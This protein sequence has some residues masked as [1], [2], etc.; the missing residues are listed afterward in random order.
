MTAL[1]CYGVVAAALCIGLPI[2][3]WILDPILDRLGL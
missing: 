2:I 3:E 1:F